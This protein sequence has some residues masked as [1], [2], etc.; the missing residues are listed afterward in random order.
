MIFINYDNFMLNKKILHNETA[1]NYNEGYDFFELNKN[2][3]DMITYN[4][5]DNIKLSDTGILMLDKDGYYIIYCPLKDGDIMDDITIDFPNDKY[6][7]QYFIG[8]NE[9]SSD[10]I[11]EFIFI[12][13][14]NQ[15]FKIRI[16]FWEKPIIYDEI[17]I[18]SRMYILND[19]DK[20]FLMNNI[21][22]TKSIIYHGGNCSRKNLDANIFNDPNPTPQ[23]FVK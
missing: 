3:I 8:D 22:V 14:N 9:Y 16:T 15:E 1:T 10:E 13:S 5:M 7:V 12:A 23:I 4:K 17:N 2:N 20:N 19:T 11:N 6:N 18:Y 21:I